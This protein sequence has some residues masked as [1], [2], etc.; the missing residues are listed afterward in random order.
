VPS[1][2]AVKEDVM[3][4]DPIRCSFI[5]L[6]TIALLALAGQYAYSAEGGDGWRKEFDD[7]CG[8]TMEA[9][10]LSAEELGK[11]VDRC[12][13]LQP[14]IEKLGESERKVFRRRLKMCRDLYRYVL[15]SKGDGK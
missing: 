3:R 8:R 1:E 2:E 9:Q 6:A 14:E 13:K 10:S 15:D 12:D 11:L 4:L 5:M 7:V